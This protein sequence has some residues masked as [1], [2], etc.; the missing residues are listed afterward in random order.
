VALL[1]DLL[2]RLG[3]GRGNTV[4]CNVILTL[5]LGKSSEIMKMQ[6]FV[7]LDKAKPDRKYKRLNLGGGHVYNCSS[8]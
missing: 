6:L 3:C 7:T 5:T 8:A 4:S 1:R 2:G